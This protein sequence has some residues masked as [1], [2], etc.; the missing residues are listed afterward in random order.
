MIAICWVLLLVSEFLFFGKHFP[1]VFLFGR[2]V[3]PL[4][5]NDLGDFR[6]SK[7]RILRDNLSLVVLAVKNEGY[8]C[9]SVKMKCG[10]GHAD[11]L[12]NRSNIPRPTT[13]A[14]VHKEF[15]KRMYV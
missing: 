11:S 6:I 14:I 3:L 5:S 4:L 8:E 10:S 12:R 9:Q 1:L 2:L 15:Q 7:P 13:G